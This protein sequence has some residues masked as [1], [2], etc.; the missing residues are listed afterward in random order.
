MSAG[1]VSDLMAHQNGVR[2]NIVGEMEAKI[3]HEDGLQEKL[4]DIC[5]THD[6]RHEYLTRLDKF[7]DEIILLNS[8]VKTVKQLRASAGKDYDAAVAHPHA[9]LET[10]ANKRRKIDFFSPAQLRTGVNKMNTAKAN[11]DLYLPQSED[12]LRLKKAKAVRKEDCISLLIKYGCTGERSEEELKALNKA[13][14]T[15]ATDVTLEDL[16]VALLVEHPNAADKNRENQYIAL[17]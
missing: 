15:V 10:D 6:G 14:K 7:S 3:T 17:L 16:V 8:P 5:S 1:K 4:H 12:D 11:G 9:V 13:K 2:C